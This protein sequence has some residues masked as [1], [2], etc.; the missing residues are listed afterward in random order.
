VKLLQRWQF[1]SQAEKSL[2]AEIALAQQYGYDGILA[3]ALDG[4]M[5]MGQ[6]DS[7][8][9]DSYDDVAASAAACHAAGLKFFVW[10]NPLDEDLDTQ[11]EMMAGCM[12]QCDGG[13]FD[14]E[15]YA[16]FWGANRPA[17]R[18]DYLM[19]EV[20]ARL[21]D[22]GKP[23]IWQPDPRPQHLAEVGGDEWGP[24]MTHYAPQNYVSDFYFVPTAELFRALQADGR[25][26]ANQYGLTYWPTLPGNADTGLMPGDAINV[27]EGFVVWRIGS[28]PA[29]TLQYLGGITLSEQPTDPCSDLA[30]QVDW[31]K[32]VVRDIADRLVADGIGAELARTTRT[33]RPAPIRR[34]VLLSIIDQ[35]QAERAQSQGP[36]E[37]AAA[38]R[39]AMSP[40]L[41]HNLPSSTIMEGANPH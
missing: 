37:P 2:D 38:R 26:I 29:N 7:G 39:G 15:P 11:A 22:Q 33:G 10:F 19:R 18:A 23:R 6:V 16:G 8:G 35:V 12:D 1:A 17:G 41:H 30:S 3:K 9:L 27:D 4:T 14:T 13:A 40:L 5:W 36:R 24:H 34:K 32:L 28:T 31:Q 21:E 20:T 25:T